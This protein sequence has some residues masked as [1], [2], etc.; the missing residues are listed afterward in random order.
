MVLFAIQ[1]YCDFGGYSC[2]AIGAA[3]IMGFDLM[4]NFN[5]PYFARSIRDFW[6]R[7]HISLS[8]WFRDYL[9]IPL[10][11]NRKGMRRKYINLMIVF[12][13]SG[14]WHGAS[15]TF[16]LWGGIHGFYQIAGG[17]LAKPKKILIEKANVRTDCLSYKFLQTAVTFGLVT[18]AWNFFRADSIIAA[19][20][21]IKHVFTQASPWIF[22]DG[23]LYELG[24]DRTEMNILIVSIVILLL[25]DL[26]RY[27]L[28]QTLDE[29]LMDQNLWFE[30]AVVIGLIVMIFVY[31]E[32]GAS[33]DPQQFIYFQF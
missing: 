8:T 18:A 22:F 29:F 21:I 25:V 26:V 13:V 17:I 9:Y 31:G 33:F 28:K 20:K 15:W 24:L 14:L 6:S 5:A 2:M 7:W 11:G 19:L 10:G 30:W 27:N 3:K 23:T 1:I 12:L 16:V 4:E 32:Y